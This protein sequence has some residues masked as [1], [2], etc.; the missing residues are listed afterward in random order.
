MTT[1]QSKKSAKAKTAT[2]TTTS[3]LRADVIRFT[4]IQGVPLLA[5]IATVKVA[6]LVFAAVHVYL[7]PETGVSINTNPLH[8]PDEIEVHVEGPVHTAILD[9]VKDIEYLEG[10]TLNLTLESLDA[11]ARRY[12]SDVLCLVCL[13]T[14]QEYRA[15]I[16]VSKKFGKGIEYKLPLSIIIELKEHAAHL[17]YAM[18]ELLRCFMNVGCMSPIDLVKRSHCAEVSILMPLAIGD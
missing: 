16:T 6:G 1:L 2:Q 17:D 8:S 11:A 9:A 5:G 15:S 3:I 7:C 14:D 18:T 10:P 12:Y 4:S 13:Y